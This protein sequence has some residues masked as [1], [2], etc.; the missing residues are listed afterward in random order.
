MAKRW[1]E[2]DAAFAQAARL[3]PKSVNLETYLR[4]RRSSWLKSLRSTRR[5]RT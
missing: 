2:A 3:D 1:A 4:A 5:P